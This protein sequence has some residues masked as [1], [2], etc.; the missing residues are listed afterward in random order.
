DSGATWTSARV[1]GT[2]PVPTN[3]EMGRIN[4]TAVPGTPDS[5]TATVYAL[6][7]NQNGS[8][9]V[10]IM[11]SID[12]GA[13]WTIVAQGKSATPTNPAPGATGTDCLTMDIGHGQSQYDLAIAVD[14]GNRDSVVIGGNLCG[15]RTIDGGATWQ[16]VANWLAFGG[17]EGPLGYVHADWH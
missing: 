13:T 4:L 6:A 9:T 11:R 15:A 8:A 10:A 3:G 14:P 12:G 1:A 16:M 17:D 5:S 7:G 2:L